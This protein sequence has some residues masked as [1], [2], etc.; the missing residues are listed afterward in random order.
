[1][2]FFQYVLKAHF[3]QYAGLPFCDS[4]LDWNGD[5]IYNKYPE[6]LSRSDDKIS[7]CPDLLACYDL[8]HLC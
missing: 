1:M 5:L 3:S 7:V 4:L 8:L 6:I 2:I